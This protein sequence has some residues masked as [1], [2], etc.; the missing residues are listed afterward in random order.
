VRAR[1]KAL[2]PNSLLKYLQLRQESRSLGAL[3]TR[4][5]NAANLRRDIPDI[6]NLDITP[7]WESVLKELAP[8][9]LG[10][11]GG[12]VNPG[13][14]RA[15]YY[16][17]RALQPRAVLE[18]G[19]HLGAS[20]G[21][22]ALALRNSAVPAPALVTVDILDVNGPDGAWVRFGVKQ[23]PRSALHALRCDFV[24]FVNTPSLAFLTSCKQRFDLIFLDGGH[25]ASTVY[26]EVPAALELLNPNGL[27]LLHDYYTSGKPLWSDGA[28]VVGP[29][30]AIERFKKEG[31]SMT[32]KP[33]GALPWLTKLK[34][35]VTS[36]A[37]LIRATPDH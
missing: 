18:I 29:W 27:I 10:D 35:N 23:P 7:E 32:A 22:F 2:L 24:D 1:V 30:L 28:V 19:T 3:K 11:K 36:L 12:A 15:I 6:Q 21:M 8:L 14:R 25:E 17:T 20:T 33:L 26:Q 13:D 34:S 9:Q 37:Y 16:L 31:V 4:A 5:C